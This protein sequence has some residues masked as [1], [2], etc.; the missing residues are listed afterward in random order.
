MKSWLIG[1]ANAAISGLAVSVG[2]FVAGTT[3]KQGAIMVGISVVVSMIKWMAQHP[4][5]GGAN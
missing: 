2:S 1:A 4:L 3:L 5:P